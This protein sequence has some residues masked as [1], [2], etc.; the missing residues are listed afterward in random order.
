MSSGKGRVSQSSVSIYLEYDICQRSDLIEKSLK[1]I[2]F[3]IEAIYNLIL[4]I[5]ITFK[6][7]CLSET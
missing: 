1:K 6:V 5:F 7:Q 3:F 2:Y 4:F